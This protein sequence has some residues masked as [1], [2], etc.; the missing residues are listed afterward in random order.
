MFSIP[1]VCTIHE[2]LLL[3]DVTDPL[4]V[5]QF[6]FASMYT[7]ISNVY[8]LIPS[9][10]VIVSN[11]SYKK[12][13]KLVRAELNLIVD[14]Y[15]SRACIVETMMNNMEPDNSN[16]QRLFFFCKLYNG[17]TDVYHMT[18]LEENLW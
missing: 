1:S 2:M 17:I 16:L 8:N 10:Y 6:F 7:D 13:V 4:F 15:Y 12:T 14:A 5:P 9:E 18:Q 3:M 11:Q